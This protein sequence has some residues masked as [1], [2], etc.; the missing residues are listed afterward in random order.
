MSVED[1]DA[2]LRVAE[3]VHPNYPEDRA[4]FAERLRL[5]PAGSRVLT[6][7]ENILGYVVSHPWTYGA[8]PMLDS[9]L[10]AIP[11][12]ADSYYIHDI[13]LLPAARGRG[14]AL[15]VIAAL[16][17]HAAEARFATA[18]LVAIAGTRPF[19]EARG[20]RAVAVPQ[21]AEKLASYDP[22]ACYMS[23]PLA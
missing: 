1:L 8:P 7:A 14:A 23:R 19:W 18:T 13:A 4:V 15:D 12:A 17:G 11:P 16:L 9:G 6:E 10:G 3:V 22:S 20:F 21:L 5:Y 2:V